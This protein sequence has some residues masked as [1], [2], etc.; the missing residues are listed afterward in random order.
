MEIFFIFLIIKEPT[1]IDIRALARPYYSASECVTA[2]ERVYDTVKKMHP[3]V[4]GTLCYT[5]DEFS[6]FDF[7]SMKRPL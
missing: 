7:V 3:K 2:S 6:T 1:G 4:I 5:L